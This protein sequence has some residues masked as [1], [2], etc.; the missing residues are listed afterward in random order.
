MMPKTTSI[1]PFFCV[2]GRLTQ[3]GVQFKAFHV[4]GHHDLFYA[5]SYLHYTKLWPMITMIN[6]ILVL[7]LSSYK[8][9]YQHLNKYGSLG[10]CNEKFSSQSNFL[11][12][13][14][15]SI[16]ASHFFFSFHVCPK[17]KFTA[18]KQVIFFYK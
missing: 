6:C 11:R 17:Q 13:S 5:P 14:I 9:K 8:F 2:N 15:N 12:I 18:R 3:K 16:K 1:L 7:N 4:F 10:I